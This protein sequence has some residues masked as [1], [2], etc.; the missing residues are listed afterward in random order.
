MADAAQRAILA[1][2]RNLER[3]LGAVCERIADVEKRMT[4]ISVDHV[5]YRP[6]LNDLLMAAEL[7]RMLRRRFAR[8]TVVVTCGASI[9]GGIASLL[10]AF[11]VF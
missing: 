4:E 7:R 10:R 2:I 9:G 11:G 1:R 3:S 8:V 5:R 6:I